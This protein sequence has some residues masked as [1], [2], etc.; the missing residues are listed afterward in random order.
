MPLANPMMNAVQIEAWGGPEQ[1]IQRR[2]PRPTPGCT[3]RRDGH[4]EANAA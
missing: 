3:H 2:V 1:L 4:V